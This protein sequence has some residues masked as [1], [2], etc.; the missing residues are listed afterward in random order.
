MVQHPSSPR[1]DCSS[2]PERVS[3]GRPVLPGVRCRDRP[4]RPAAGGVRLL[5]DA[6]CSCPRGSATP[7]AR[8]L[9]PD[10]QRIDA[11]KGPAE[12]LPAPDPGARVRAEPL[13]PLDSDEPP[14]PAAGLVAG[15]GTA[16]FPG[17]ADRR[18]LRGQRGATRAA[19]AA[20]PL[21]RQQ[22]HPPWHCRRRHCPRRAARLVTAEWPWRQ[23]GPRSLGP[24]RDTRPGP[25]APA[26]APVGP[27]L[28]AGLLDPLLVA[29]GQA[30]LL[31]PLAYYW[32][33]LDMADVSFLP[34]LAS[35]DPRGARPAPWSG[36]LRRLLG[37]P[38]SDPGEAAASA[39]A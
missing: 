34:V 14:D 24:V 28:A 20:D 5:R 16:A 39:F 23:D 19:G 3:Q 8:A 7:A 11:P 6:P 30:L 29:A 37:P 17:A 26:P 33:L 27:R 4:E 18:R 12:Q 13:P 2:L 10:G 21:L 36:L 32:S 25:K 22:W 9:S 1:L 38:G 35:V 31:G 15:D